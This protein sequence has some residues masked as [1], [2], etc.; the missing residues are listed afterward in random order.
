MFLSRFINIY[1]DSFRGL[2]KEIWILAFANLINRAGSMLI[3]FMSL[4]LTKEIGLSKEI[5]GISIM[6]FGFGSIVGSYL[7]GYLADRVNFLY[8]QIASLVLSAL[9][10][11][12][13]IFV[14]NLFVISGCLFLFAV[15]AD[16]FRPANTVAISH[17]STPETQ[18]RSYSLMRLAYNLGFA[19]GPAAGGII[20]G[21]L[22]FKWLFVVDALTCLVASYLLYRSFYKHLKLDK[23]SPKAWKEVKPLG[24]SAFKDYY[25]LAFIACVVLY[26]LSFMQMFTS[27][28]VHF[29]QD[30]GYSETKVGL[31][32]ALNGL[33]VFLIEMPIVA[34]YETYPHKMRLMALGCVMML[35]SYF[36]LMPFYSNILYPVCFTFFI[37]MS[38]IF[39]MPFMMN[40]VVNRPD[41]SRRGQYSSLYSIA[42]GVGFI[43]APALGLWVADNYSFFELFILATALSVIT[44]FVFIKLGDKLAPL[45][46]DH[47][48][49]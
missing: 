14:K 43:L 2:T 21:L 6:A 3:P 47:N 28:P 38:E 48:T 23:V 35:I 19:I 33:L 17:F 7:G 30:L 29:A 10:L 41:P 31:L 9:L 5:A 39:A 12:P 15:I 45:R 4:F 40:F 1:T 34:V 42:F 11:V 24:I 26:C 32:L 49:V 20:A 44:A 25:Y 37:T 8:V 18:T 13:F 36:F 22:G 16:A 46:L 27:V